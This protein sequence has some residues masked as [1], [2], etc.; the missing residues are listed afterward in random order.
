MDE[1]VKAI[2]EAVRAGTAAAFPALVGYYILRG[3]EALV[4][5]GVVAAFVV[6]VGRTVRFVFVQY[7]QNCQHVTALAKARTELYTAYQ[8]A[9]RPE[10]LGL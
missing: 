2:A 7:G 6:P 1:L 4:P 9:G 3:I 8:K 5:I 10:G